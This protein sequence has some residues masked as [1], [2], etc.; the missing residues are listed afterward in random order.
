MSVA[1]VMPSFA[2]CHSHVFHRALRGRGTSGRHFW[3]WRERMY[4]TAAALDPE[5][6]HE[7]AR[8]TFREMRLSGISSVG[9]FHYLHHGPD[10]R[11]YDDPNAMGVAVIEA[12]RDAGLRIC[13]LDACYLQSGFDAPTEGVQVRFDDG[14][15]ERWAERVA[16]LHARYAGVPDVVV[17]TAIH[18]VRAVGTADLPTVVDAL[19][20]AP[21]HVHVSEQVR[22]NEECLQ[23]TGR[24]P[25]GLLADAGAW[26]PRTT[27]VHAV[28][29]EPDEIAVLAESG[30]TV[31]LCPTTE[32]ELADGIAPSVALQDAGVP[33]TLGSDSQTVIDPFLEA[34]ALDA[35]ERLTSGRRDGWPHD[36]LL[37]AATLAGHRSLGLPPGPTVTVRRSV[38]TAGGT[39]PLGSA[40]AADL[41]PPDDLDPDEVGARLHR[42]I[43][44]LAARS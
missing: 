32:A 43:E 18:S 22:E 41:V 38:R 10:G 9:E 29:L 36:R 24:R 28:H 8:W 17:G 11:P 14:S 20:D 7:L 1:A 33:I 23:A 15:A 16:D 44:D 12:A 2:N 19:P 34:R 30:A 39:L 25:V 4:A 42:V 37:E 35:H 27:A 13:L 6:L 26:S 40:T 5:S 21:L 3:A 31:C